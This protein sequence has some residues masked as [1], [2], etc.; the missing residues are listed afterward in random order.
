MLVSHTGDTFAMT[1]EGRSG[2]GVVRWDMRM[3]R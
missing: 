3:P 2:D 1:F